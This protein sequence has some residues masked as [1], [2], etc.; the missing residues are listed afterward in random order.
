MTMSHALARMRVAWEWS[1]QGLDGGESASAVTDLGEESGC[2]HD[3][4]FGEA[5]EDVRVGVRGQLGFEGVLEGGD[6]HPQRL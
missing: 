5:G 4:G 1:L 6:L 2:P 3:S